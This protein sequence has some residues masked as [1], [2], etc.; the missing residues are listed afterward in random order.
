MI[1]KIAIEQLSVGMFIHDLDT[2]WLEHPFLHN[3]FKVADPSTVNKIRIIGVKHIYIDTNRGKDLDDAP[4]VEDVKKITGRRMHQSLSGHAPCLRQTSTTEESLAAKLIYKEAHHVVHEL[5]RDV[6]LGK[7][8]QVEKVEPLAEKIIDSVFRNKD[9]LISLTRIKRK[10]QYTFMHCVSVC[11]LLTAFAREQ[12]YDR[13]AMRE[14]AIGAL[15]H[16]IG[17]TYIPDVIL[18][19]PGKLSEDEF[20]LMKNH[21]LYSRDILQEYRNISETSVRIAEQHHERI[22][23]TGYPYGLTQSQLPTTSQMAAIVDVYDALTSVRCYKDAWEPT[24][25]LAKLLEW[26]PMHFGTELVQRFIRVLG[27]YPVGSLVELDSGKVGIVIEQGE[28]D[29]LKPVVRLVY[30]SRRQHYIP[31]KD[32]DLG[33][34]AQ[35]H[36]YTAVTPQKYHINPAPFL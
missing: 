17:K 21:V 10:D 25:T 31:V 14:V 36:I 3:R 15:L 32:L 26:S 29:Y 13:D 20:E 16:D 30:D 9:A 27:I 5:M 2:A 1:K 33:K 12:G 34:N 35:E 8:V 19:K 24:Y 7:Q 23:G 11:A 6:R 28:T 18:N 4:T 22:D